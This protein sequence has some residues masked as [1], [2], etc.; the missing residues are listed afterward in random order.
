[1]NLASETTARVGMSTFPFAR[2]VTLDL[3]MVAFRSARNWASENMLRMMVKVVRHFPN[4]AAS[5]FLAA[6]PA[7]ARS[8]SLL[9]ASGE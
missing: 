7:M 5:A 4:P 9:V 1:V 2:F 6:G 3:L 8:I